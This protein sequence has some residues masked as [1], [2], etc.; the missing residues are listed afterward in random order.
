MPVERAFAKMR[1]VLCSA[2][3]LSVLCLC[4]VCA[5]FNVTHLH[6]CSYEWC[7]L[8]SMTMRLL[9]LSLPAAGLD[10]PVR[11]LVNHRKSLFL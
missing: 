4:F 9:N 5:L 6:V 2:C 10:S 3:A 7:A 11:T 8:Q 1:V